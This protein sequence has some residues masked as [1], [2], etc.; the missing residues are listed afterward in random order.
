MNPQKTVNV[1]ATPLASTT[2][3]EQEQH[4]DKCKGVNLPLFVHQLPSVLRPLD[5]FDLRDATTLLMT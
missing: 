2:L 3:D 1:F 5:I 4:P